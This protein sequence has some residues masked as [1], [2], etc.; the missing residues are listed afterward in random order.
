[1]SAFRPLLVVFCFFTLP[2]FAR[3]ITIE[4]LVSAFG[5]LVFC[6][7]ELHRAIQHIMVYR[8]GRRIKR[9]VHRQLKAA[10]APVA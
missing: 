9:A 7:N 8:S 1:M 10:A 5:F 6:L 2:E 4:N 3:H